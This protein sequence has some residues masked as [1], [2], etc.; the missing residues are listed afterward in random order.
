MKSL[1][2]IGRKIFPLLMAAVLILSLAGPLSK[3]T[4]ASD[5]SEGTYELSGSLSAYLTA[6]GGV[7][8][9]SPLLTGIYLVVDES[10]NEYLKL[11]FTKSSVT[12]Y[13]ITCDTFVD[14]NPTDTTNT[15]GVANGTMGIYDADGNLVECSE[16]TLS[17]DTALNS[18]DEA[19]NYVDS[20]T[21]PISSREETYNLAIYINSNVMGVEFCNSNS[22]ATEATYSATLTVDWSAAEAAE[23]AAEETTEAETTTQETTTEETEEESLEADE[24]ME[25]LAIY[26][27]DDEEGSSAEAEEET[28]E[29]TSSS[30]I[31]RTAL[32]IIIIAVIV[33]I[34]AVVII[35]IAVRKHKKSKNGP[36][37]PAPEAEEIP[38]EETPSDETT[39]MD[40][41]EVEK[42]IENSEGSK[43]T[44]EETEENR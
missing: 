27:A 23:T 2:K 12:I 29:E 40:R 20:I 13:S 21:Y 14:A 11:T 26:N 10:G 38:G 4:Y 37:G 18:A 8:F 5:L 34:I 32:I 16:Y 31:G 41:E 39:V 35:I 42:E 33:V 28:S 44:S 17:S 30:G 36:E 7:E 22:S 24:E 9:G 1:K 19:V 3:E 6:M 15:R 25:G 43:E